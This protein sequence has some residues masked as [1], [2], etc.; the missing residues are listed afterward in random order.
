MKILHGHSS[1]IFGMHIDGGKIYSYSQD[2]T[3]RIWNIKVNFILV[4]V[5]F[6]EI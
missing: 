3:V 4:N 5:I 6:L 1:F 2:G